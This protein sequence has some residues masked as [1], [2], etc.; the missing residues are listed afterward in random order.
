MMDGAQKNR[1]S[2]KNNKI[3]FL[4][5]CFERGWN[6]WWR[7]DAGE[8]GFIKNMLNVR[9]SQHERERKIWR[10]EEI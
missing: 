6:G 1:Q 10:L 7:E 3:G 5:K 8:I 2:D 9:L 4:Q